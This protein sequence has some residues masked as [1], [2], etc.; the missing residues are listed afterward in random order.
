MNINEIYFNNL[1]IIHICKTNLKNSYIS[2][3]RTGEITL[4]TPKVSNEYIAKLLKDRESWIRKQLKTVQSNLSKKINIQDEVLLFGEI[5]SID[6]DEVKDLRDALVNIDTS[7]IANILKKYDLFYKRYA[8]NYI[9]PRVQHYSEV[10]N[11]IYSDI[12]FRKMRSRWGSCS[13]KGIITLNTELIKIEKKFI[14]Y[15][16]VHELAHLVHMNHS[17]KFHLLVEEYIP[18]AKALNRELKYFSLY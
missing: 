6:S 2:V 3:K 4:K 16:I 10:M 7:N 18:N 11:L 15:I 12:K 13:S 14:D 5:F 9:A 1:H 17:K 8:Q